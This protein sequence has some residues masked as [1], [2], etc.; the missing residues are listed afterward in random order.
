MKKVLTIL[1]LVLTLCGCKEKT[2]ETISD[3]IETQPQAVPQKVSLAL[4]RGAAQSAMAEENGDAVYFCDGYTLSVATRAGGDMN[5]TIRWLTGL[6]ADE[7]S[8]IEAKQGDYKSTYCAWCSAGEG[9]QKI[10][11]AKILDDGNY[12]YTVSVLSDGE[13]VAQYVDAWEELFQ[14]VILGEYNSATS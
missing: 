9:G 3:Q 1:L 5:A 12:H 14:S 2:W 11:R 4:P 7:L 6:P 10:G 13:D 8:I